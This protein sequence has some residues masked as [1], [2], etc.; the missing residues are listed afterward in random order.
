MGI[1]KNLYG[2]GNDFTKGLRI[3]FT[4][5]TPGMKIRSKGMGRGLA[6]G[7][8]RGPIGVPYRRKKARLDFG[9]FYNV[10]F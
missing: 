1:K 8:G 6:R 3:G 9:E 5:P 10:G 2:I 4:C 7:R